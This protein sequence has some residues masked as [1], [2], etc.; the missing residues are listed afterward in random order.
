VAADELA[1]GPGGEPARRR[2]QAADF[3]GDAE[4]P[5]RA[6]APESPGAADGGGAL[7][8]RPA[9]LGG[10]GALARDADAPVPVVVLVA[11]MGRRGARGNG[12]ERELRPSGGRDL[13]RRVHPCGGR[14]ALERREGRD[15]LLRGRGRRVGR[16]R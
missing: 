1:R 16:G 15:V 4:R 6:A 10:R 11:R 2:V 7:L 12:R 8:L 13:H 14:T 3:R 5:G 9:G